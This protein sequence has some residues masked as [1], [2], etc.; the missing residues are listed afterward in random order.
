METY[1]PHHHAIYSPDITA[2]L[3]DPVEFKL[4]SESIKRAER[5]VNDEIINEL[6]R[7]E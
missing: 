3:V 6:L 7:G 2:W 4:E 1:T 5:A